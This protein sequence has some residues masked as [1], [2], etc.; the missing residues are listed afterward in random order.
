MVFHNWTDF[1]QLLLDGKCDLVLSAGISETAR[2]SKSRNTIG[3]SDRSCG[4][5]VC[6]ADSVSLREERCASYQ[7]DANSN[8]DM[9]IKENGKGGG[10]FSLDIKYE[11]D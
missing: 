6:G 10:A 8:M 9:R 4:S 5:S 1:R 11:M 3:L 7:I 2:V